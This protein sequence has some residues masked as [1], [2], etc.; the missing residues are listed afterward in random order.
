MGVGLTTQSS[1]GSQARSSALQLLGAVPAEERQADAQGPDSPVPTQDGFTQEHGAEE[2]VP[3]LGVLIYTKEN[4]I[5]LTATDG[6]ATRQ[7]P[8]NTELRAGPYTAQPRSLSKREKNCG[9]R[10]GQKG[11]PA[12]RAGLHTYT[13]FSCILICY[14]KGK[15]GERDI[16]LSAF[17]LGELRCA[18]HTGTRRARTGTGNHSGCSWG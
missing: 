12:A 4:P 7:A 8:D 2:G 13:D 10:G 15:E 5:P 11:S 1:G 3:G 14:L 16:R 17:R 6:A 9:A 18:T